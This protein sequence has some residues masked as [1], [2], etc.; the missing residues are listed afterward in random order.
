[1]TR[2][3]LIGMMFTVIPFLW[4]GANASAADILNFDTMA[5]VP[6]VGFAI[7]GISGGGSPWVVDVA[8]GK[9]GEDGRLQITVRGLVLA[10]SGENP[11]ATFSGVVSC[12][13]GFGAEV[14][15]ST[16]EVSTGPEGD[17]DIDEMLALPKPC[18]APMALVVGASGN[19][20]AVSGGGSDELADEDDP[21]E[22]D[23]PDE[24]DLDEPDDDDM[25]EVR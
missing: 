11:S 5:G 3:L 9:V 15:V 14:N 21:D 8:N 22:P 6:E 1:M 10:T 23:E 4:A 13:D 2:K 18:F 25:D 19:W 12:I 16:A 7:R 17:A 24:P 20:F